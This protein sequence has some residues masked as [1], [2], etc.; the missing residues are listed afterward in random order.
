MQCCHE[1]T[2]SKHI[3]HGGNHG[4]DQLCDHVC[5][6][7][8]DQLFRSISRRCFVMFWGTCFRQVPGDAGI[9]QEP[10]SGVD[11]AH[12]YQCSHCCID[13]FCPHGHHMKHVSRTTHNSQDVSPTKVSH[14]RLHVVDAR[15]SV[16]T[17]QGGEAQC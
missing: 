4:G 9:T 5:N 1:A 17:Y 15:A 16:R 7:E 14:T 3:D 11:Q 8:G 2:V 10:D 13:Q 12:V 6:D